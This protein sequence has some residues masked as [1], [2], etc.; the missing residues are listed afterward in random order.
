MVSPQTNTTLE[1]IAHV[2]GQH[3]SFALCGHVNPDGDCMGSELALA[4]ALKFL[5]KEVICL[6]AKDEPLDE[7]FLSLPGASDCIPASH[8]HET[9]EVFIAVD[10]PTRDR[11]GLAAVIAKKAQLRITL[12]HHASE[13]VMSEFNFVEPQAASASMI[14]WELIKHLD[15]VNPDSAQCALCGLVTDTGKFSYQNTS[16]KA[17]LF[18]S[19]MM[20]AGADPA[21]INRAFFQN[22]S[23]PSLRLEQIMLDR[24]QFKHDGQ[25]AFSHL[26]LKDFE[27]CGA[28][29][30][31]AEMLIDILRDI[32][33]VRVALI[34]REA[35]QNEVRGS[36]RA[37]DDSD[38]AQ[39][40]RFFD[41][42][43]HKAAAGFTFYGSIDQAIQQV[44]AKVSELLF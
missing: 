44:G 37:K 15:A 21:S 27:Q 6:L 19:E 20:Q 26:Y 4:H 34:L 5:N 1:A 7:N 25:F 12:D 40:A 11:T 8:Y 38:V 13:E 42:G 33:G 35:E 43:G 36:L 9:P 17:F 29:K 39:I 41:G 24:M 28:S 23:I 18:A 10:V 32:R 14:I 31:D 3:H 2:I 16:A 22:R 30:P